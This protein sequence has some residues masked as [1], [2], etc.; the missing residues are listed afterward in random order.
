MEL[1][2]QQAKKLLEPALRGDPMEPGIRHQGSAGGCGVDTVRS[3]MSG[4]SVLDRL[5]EHR[6][7]RNKDSVKAFSN[8]PRGGPISIEFGKPLL[9]D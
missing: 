5:V 8:A 2:T 4:G 7:E 1:S 9:V 3:P 6:L